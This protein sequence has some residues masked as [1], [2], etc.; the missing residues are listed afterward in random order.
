MHHTAFISCYLFF[1]VLHSLVPLGFNRTISILDVGSYDVN[2]NNK[3]CIELSDFGK[4]RKFSYTGV[5]TH[6]GPNVDVVQNVGSGWLFNNSQFDIIMSTSC[7]EHDDFFWITF[8]NIARSL[9]AGGIIWINVPGGSESNKIHRYPVDNYRFFPDAAHALAKWGQLD[10]LGPHNLDVIHS[11]M[12]GYN[13]FDLFYEEKA[14]YGDTAMIFFKH[15]SD[16]ITDSESASLLYK[17]LREIVDEPSAYYHVST[18][19][20]D[21]IKFMLKS[22]FSYYKLDWMML[23]SNLVAVTAWDNKPTMR[24]IEVFHEGEEI[25]S[26]PRHIFRG[27]SAYRGYCLFDYRVNS[28]RVSVADLATDGSILGRYKAHSYLSHDIVDTNN[29]VEVTQELEEEIFHRIKIYFL[30]SV[31]LRNAMKRFENDYVISLKSVPES[32][33][34]SIGR[35]QFAPPLGALADITL[36]IQWFVDPNMKR[37]DVFDEISLQRFFDLATITQPETVNINEFQESIRQT[38][39]QQIARRVN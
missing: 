26:V 19:V 22:E 9:R 18:S 8:L 6:A 35:Y 36:P 13:S 4:T 37:L 28:S 32:F 14:I 30:R 3:D 2:G 24:K 17:A 29:P 15:S 25:P 31:T 1:Q 27:I 5:D 16:E 39:N 38:I 10:P 33:K 34:I 23:M 21:N 20:S 11:S 7:L 12:L